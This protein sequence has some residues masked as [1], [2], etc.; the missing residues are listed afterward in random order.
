MFII[1]PLLHDHV[2]SIVPESPRWLLQHDRLED[3]QHVLSTIASRNGRPKPDFGALRQIAEA[4]RQ[5]QRST[6]KYTYLD[7]LRVWTYCKRTLIMFLAW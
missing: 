4:D 5:A 3:A 2:C 6:K 7:I 1:C